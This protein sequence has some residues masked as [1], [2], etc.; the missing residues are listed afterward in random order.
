VGGEREKTMGERERDFESLA[1]HTGV[2]SAPFNVCV[3]VCVCVYRGL[4]DEGRGVFFFHSA[5]SALSFG[6][7]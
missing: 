1:L 6:K 7:L 3:C 2:R 5:F 4:V